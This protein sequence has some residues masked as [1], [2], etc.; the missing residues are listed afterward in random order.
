M[1]IRERVRNQR[2]SSWDLRHHDPCL[3]K[4]L[5][6][7]TSARVPSDM[8]RAIQNQDKIEDKV[9]EKSEDKIHE[10]FEYKIKEGVEDILGQ[11]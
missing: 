11:S 10:D 5:A 6:P 7:K 3:T 9:D 4:P 8:Y 1:R 2:V